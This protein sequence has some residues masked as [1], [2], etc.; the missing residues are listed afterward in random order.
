[1]KHEPHDHVLSQPEAV[2]LMKTRLG[3]FFPYL[4]GLGGSANVK[5]K[6]ANADYKLSNINKSWCN[7]VQIVVR[8]YLDVRSLNCCVRPVSCDVTHVAFVLLRHD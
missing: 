7:P 2:K 1:M 6:T 8:L 4:S 3:R 5:V